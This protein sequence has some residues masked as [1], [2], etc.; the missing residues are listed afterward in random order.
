MPLTQPQGAKLCMEYCNHDSG[1]AKV[2]IRQAALDLFYTNHASEKD[3]AFS[4]GL[5]NL[6]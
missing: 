2:S 6:S 3:L 4:K 5:S 1:S